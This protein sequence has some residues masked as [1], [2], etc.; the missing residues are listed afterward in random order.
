MFLSL[1]V[2]FL[3][4]LSLFWFGKQ[5]YEKS[6][7]KRVPQDLFFRD[8]NVWMVLFIF[9]LLSGLRYRVGADYLSYAWYFE[10]LVEWNKIDRLYVSIEPLFEWITRVIGRF[11][12]LSVE[13]YFGFLAF[14][15]MFFLY[16]ALRHRKFLYPYIGL[17]L[18][19]GQ[20]Y[21]CWMNGI[22]QEIVGCVFVFALVLLTDNSTIK[23][24]LLYVGIILLCTFM[25]KS[26][27]ILL[28]FA[29]IPNWDYF[30][31]R[32]VCIVVLI[33]CAY[34]GMTDWV[35]TNLQFLGKYIELFGNE[36]YVRN[37]DIAMNYDHA[38]VTKYGPRRIILLLFNI[39]IVWF[40]NDLKRYFKDDKF[41]LMCYSLFFVYACFNDLFAGASH[42]FL[43]PVGYLQPFSLICMAYL[44]FYLRN[45]K[46]VNAK[47]YFVVVLLVACSYLLVENLAVKDIKGEFSLYKF[48]FLED[49]ERSYDVHNIDVF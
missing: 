9:A 8:G 6:L 11:L 38:L 32:Y 40:S 18:I 29:F 43:R 41:F 10:R 45:L 49:T 19:L 21:L 42:M 44:L 22:R 20:Y 31:N 15:Q 17:V 1:S 39:L 46:G 48:R 23:N 26:A 36:K 16:Y 5:S 14:V 35:Q 24:R 47:M 13:F 2:Y 12:G 4:A 7:N 28:P 25:H 27:Y 33:L 3:F 30:K 37:F 34:I